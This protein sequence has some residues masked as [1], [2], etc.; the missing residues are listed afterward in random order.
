MTKKVTI[1]L[2]ETLIN[3]LNTAAQNLGKTKTQIIREALR[4][5]LKIS[6]KEEKIALWEKENKDAIESYNKMFEED[7]LILKNNRMF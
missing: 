5:Y 1:S 3:E 6:S 2:E 4:S 7:G